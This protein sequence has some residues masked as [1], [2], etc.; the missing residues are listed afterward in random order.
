[1]RKLVGAILLF[2][3]A[4]ATVSFGKSE[5]TIEQLI[6]RADAAR[7]DQQPDL[8]MQVAQ[9]E[10]KSA[11]EAYKTEQMEEFRTAVQ[12]IVKYSDS[13]HSAA[14]HSGK[15][16]KPTEIKIR[17]IAIRLRDIKLNVEADEQPA[18]QAA[19]ERLESFR[20]E[21]LHSMFGSKS[22]N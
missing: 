15:H 9:R 2:L 14:L 22:N 13:A 17:E 21:L 8:Y 3:L 5:E 11:T 4:A 19:I 10:L 1:M 12:Q 7:P 6:A 18:V 16:L 20:T